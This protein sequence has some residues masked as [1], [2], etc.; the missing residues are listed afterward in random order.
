MP[1]GDENEVNIYMDVIEVDVSAEIVP[2]LL[3]VEVVPPYYFKGDPGDPGPSGTPVEL[4]V[5]SSHIQWRYVGALNW[6]DLIALSELVQVVSSNTFYQEILL[7][8]DGEFRHVLTENPIPLTLRVYINGILQ[9]STNI[10]IVA[11]EIV[12]GVEYN[13]LVDDRVIITYNYL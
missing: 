1:A 13:L 4:R 7:T 11:G 8:A 10:P 5:T 9:S 3:P 6:I 12:L 2:P